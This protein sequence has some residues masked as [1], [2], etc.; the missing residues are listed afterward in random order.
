MACKNAKIGPRM[1]HDMRRTAVRNLVR[2]GV[3]EKI[4]MVATGHLTRSIFDR[5]DIINEAD[6][7]MAAEMR[8]AYLKV[9][10]S[11]TGSDPK[12]ASLIPLRPESKHKRVSRKGVK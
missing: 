8:E 10:E 5:Y 2:A 3:P 4:C 11:K 1:L 12:I 7:K 6:M 9:L